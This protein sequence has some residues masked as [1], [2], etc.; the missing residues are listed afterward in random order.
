MLDLL[1]YKRILE[2]KLINSNYACDYSVTM[3]ASKIKLI[4][5]GCKT[6]CPC[7]TGPTLTT[8]TTAV[9]TYAYNV[10]FSYC[11]T[12]DFAIQGVIKNIG[13][14]TVGA[15]YHDVIT[16]YN[17]L[18][19]SFIGSSVG[20]DRNILNA[21]QTSACINIK[22]TTTTTTTIA[23]PTTTSTT[24]TLAPT[25][26]TTS[27]SSTSSTSTSTSSTSTTST[28]TIPGTTTT[29]TTNA[30]SIVILAEHTQLCFGDGG[31]RVETSV[32]V[33][34]NMTSSFA[35]GGFYHMGVGFS[36]ANIVN[37]VVNSMTVFNFGIEASNGGPLTQNSSILFTINDFNTNA[38]IASYTL[39]RNHALNPC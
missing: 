22:C 24:T 4:T 21:S 33:K 10:S 14:L 1:N 16:G 25:T 37:Q 12:C 23:P 3:I 34:V 9:P 32:P 13:S 29:T 27:S 38:T 2:Y 20:Y 7:S 26:T 11:D 28:T 31:V 30:S 36:S 6:K 39:H 5:L 19:D 17:I 18:I 35:P 15:W 8:T